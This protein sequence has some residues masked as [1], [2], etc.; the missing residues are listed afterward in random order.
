MTEK[1]HTKVVI[2][3]SRCLT[4]IKLDYFEKKMPDITYVSKEEN[5]VAGLKT[6]TF[7]LKV[8]P[9]AKVDGFHKLEAYFIMK[10]INLQ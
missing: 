6:A 1:L 8:L 3:H 5:T 2:Q 9:G 7:K 4:W 10:K